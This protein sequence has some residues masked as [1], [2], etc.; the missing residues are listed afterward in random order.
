MKPIELELLLNFLI[1]EMEKKGLVITNYTFALDEEF[2]DICN[3]FCGTDSSIDK[4]KEIL[5]QS[6][7]HEYIKNRT[8]DPL[9]YLAIT[10]KGLGVVS[11]NR[12]KKN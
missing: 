9:T 11:S 12:L 2:V 7:T 1:T 3:E 4:Y 5:Q 8:M 10:Q 6:I